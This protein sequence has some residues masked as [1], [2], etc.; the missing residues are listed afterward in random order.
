MKIINKKVRMEAK[1]N[2]A[3]RRREMGKSRN[4]IEKKKEERG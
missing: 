3:V 1:V 2:T 4:K